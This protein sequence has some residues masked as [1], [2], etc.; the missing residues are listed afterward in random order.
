MDPVPEIGEHTN[1][2]LKE[3]GLEDAQITNMKITEAI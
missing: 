3:L 1:A 2:I